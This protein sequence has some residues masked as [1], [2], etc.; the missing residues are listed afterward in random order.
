MLDGH[1]H[2]WNSDP[3]DC[4]L[5]QRMADAGFYG[6]LLFSLPPAGYQERFTQVS[7]VRLE[8][9]MAA[10]KSLK[11]CF[12]FFWID[13]LELDALEQ[14]EKAAEAGVDGFKVICDRFYPYEERPM[15]LFRRIAEMKFP[16]TFHSGIL[17]DGK[18]SSLYNRP[19]YFECLMQIPN[20]RFALAHLAWPWCD[21][22]LAV[23]LLF[24]CRE[25]QCKDSAQMFIDNTAGTP[26]IYRHDA[27]EKLFNVCQVKDRMFFGSDFLAEDYNTKRAMDLVK[28][29]NDIYK[30]LNISDDEYSNFY[31]NNL[32]KFVKG[33][34]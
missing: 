5:V 27:M 8:H 24:R 26:H 12:R 25:A 4:D 9:L 6:G 34:V 2:L 7:S 30:S 28:R 15:Q 11:K 32:I 3:A 23:Y 21:E 22:H 13:P 29:D 14:L 1:I 31:E 17:G 10:G 19:V 33:V 16:L 18:F 20:L